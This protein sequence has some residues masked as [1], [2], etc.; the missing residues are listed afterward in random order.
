M[1]GIW[2]KVAKMGDL[3]TN[4][5]TR[6]KSL[7]DSL[8]KR[9]LN[10]TILLINVGEVLI[11]MQNGVGFGKAEVTGSSPVISSMQKATYL[12]VFFVCFANN[13]L[14]ALHGA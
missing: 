9:W 6:E 1:V 14:S 8:T 11:L 12:V 7:C 3:G 13:V 2:S 5:H 4:C 10:A